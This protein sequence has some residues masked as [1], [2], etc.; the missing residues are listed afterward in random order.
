MTQN[1]ENKT[2]CDLIAHAINPI[3]SSDLIGC[4]IHNNN[5]TQKQ[6][7]P[8]PIQQQSQA[9]NGCAPLP[10][11]EPRKHPNPPTKLRFFLKPPLNGQVGDTFQARGLSQ[12]VIVFL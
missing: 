8:F 9:A 3:K 1:N 12:S 2:D 4:S 5:Q 10:Q 6:Q 7:T 11:A